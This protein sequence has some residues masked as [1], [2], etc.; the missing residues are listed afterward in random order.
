MLQL[1][2]IKLCKSARHATIYA[3]AGL[4]L[5]VYDACTAILIWV[6]PN[7]HFKSTL[8]GGGHTKEYAVYARENDDN[9][10]RPLTL[11]Q[12]TQLNV[13]TEIPFDFS[14]EYQTVPQPNRRATVLERN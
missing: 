12:I 10:G 1:S 2:T 3:A 14:Q 13:I 7:Q 5:R 8:L 6:I 11:P 9:S 4:Q